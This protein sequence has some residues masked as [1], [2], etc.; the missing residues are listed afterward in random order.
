MSAA[1]L[2]ITGTIPGPLNAEF[3]VPFAA[4][5]TSAIGA[6]GPDQGVFLAPGPGLNT[7]LTAAALPGPVNLTAQ[8]LGSP[9]G[10]DPGIDY[11]N[12]TKV[13]ESPTASSTSPGGGNGGGGRGFW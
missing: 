8:G 13:I 4:P 10:T 7:S 12:G 11:A 5:N 3:Y 6:G 9:W 1:L 2:N